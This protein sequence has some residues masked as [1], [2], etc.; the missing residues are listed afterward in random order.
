[1]KWFCSFLGILVAT[2]A[3][4]AAPAQLTL[5]N[6]ANHQADWDYYRP[7][8]EAVQ[9]E[10][11]G[12]GEAKSQDD[13]AQD[14]GS[15]P[16]DRYGPRAN[17]VPQPSAELPMP[18]LD[19]N[20]YLDAGRMAYE[21]ACCDS[22]CIPQFQPRDWNSYSFL[23]HPVAV[24]GQCIEVGGWLS[25]GMTFAD[26]SV[27]TTT[28]LAFVNPTDEFLFNQAWVYAQR[29]ANTQGYGWDW[30]FRVD[31]VFG[32]D[33]PDTQARGDRGWDFGW[34]TGGTGGNTYGSAIPQLY[35]EAAYNDLTVKL[36][37]FFTIMGYERVPA[38]SNF[39]YSHS[40]AMNYGAP[41]TQTG[42]LAEYPTHQNVTWFAGYVTGWDSGF[43]NIL[44]AH[45]FLGGVSSEI[46]DGLTVAYTVNTGDFGDGTAANNVPSNAGDIFLQS[47]VARL[48]LARRWQYVMQTDYGRNSGVGSGNNEW[49]GLTQYLMYTINES[50]RA[51]LRYEVF[52]DH[53]GTSGRITNNAETYHAWSLG[54]NWQPYANLRIR[55][56]FRWDYVDHSTG[57]FGGQNS[58]FT[59]GVDAIFQF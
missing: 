54:T 18:S 23:P 49:Y 41:L 33:A 2:S 34:N 12:Q 50:W 11:T 52:R 59:F 40:Y 44:N 46:T 19:P 47:F 10:A 35:A 26:H 28:P 42:V 56:E 31:Y 6:P 55:P 16:S 38:P 7:H 30:G 20:S 45:T 4:V 29:R 9:D 57:P 53:A 13:T 17:Q 24:G 48:D 8:Q 51:G 36:G 58:L 37:H 25:G 39:F 15:S 5:N 3:A 27:G 1:M 43:E 32:A 14:P 22:L 21:S